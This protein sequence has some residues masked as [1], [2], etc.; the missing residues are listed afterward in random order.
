MSLNKTSEGT[1]STNTAKPNYGTIDESVNVRERA[2]IFG[3]RNAADQNTHKLR[4]V[5]VITPPVQQNNTKDRLPAAEIKLRAVSVG[6]DAKRP[7]I[8]GSSGGTKILASP[9]ITSSSGGGNMTSPNK[10]KNMAAMF[11]QNVK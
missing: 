11:E 1:T 7:V 6:G 10:I 8:T 3:T 4:T 5:S 9:V 2:S